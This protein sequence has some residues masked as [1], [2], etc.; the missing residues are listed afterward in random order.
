MSEIDE[1]KLQE[2]KYDILK[3]EDE[4][5]K[6]KELTNSDMVDKIKQII[7]NESMDKNF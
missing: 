5:A 2:M 3:L 4:N 7:T 6:T 1:G